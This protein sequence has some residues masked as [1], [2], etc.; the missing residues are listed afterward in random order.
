[1]ASCTASPALGGELGV[2]AFAGGV[3]ATSTVSPWRSSPSAPAPPRR[4]ERRLPPRSSAS[5]TR[6]SSGSAVSA[7]ADLEEGGVTAGRVVAV[8]AAACWAA[9]PAGA[10]GTA[11]RARRPAP[12]MLRPTL[13]TEG[14]VLI[15]RPRN[16]RQLKA[17]L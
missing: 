16:S 8:L 10:G 17:A 3:S 14:R 15:S 2:G 6:P 5:P 12:P 9:D 1:M 13:A 11:A 4:R 7:L